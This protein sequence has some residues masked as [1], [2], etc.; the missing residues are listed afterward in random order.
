MR[1]SVCWVAATSLLLAACAAPLDEERQAPNP[2]S[3]VDETGR[4]WATRAP[5]ETIRI[6]GR[7]FVAE[8]VR[9]ALP[10]RLL[11]MPVS[12]NVPFGDATFADLVFV[13]E[14]QGV[15]AAYPWNI[16][17]DL[18]AFMDRPLTF[19]RYQGT[20][21]GL[22]S[23]LRNAMGISA[24]YSDGAVFFSPI[25][26][27]AVSIP[28]IES[29]LDLVASELERMGASDVQPSQVASQILYSASPA[30][31]RDLIDPFLRRSAHNLSE[32]TMQIALVTVSLDDRDERG[33]D[34]DTF[35]ARLE[36]RSPTDAADD[37]DDSGD[38]DDE[39]GG[40]DQGVNLGG[41]GPPIPTFGF[42]NL[43]AGG[44]EGAFFDDD[45]RLFGTD[46]TVTVGAAIDFLSQLGTSRVDQNLEMRTISGSSV[47]LRSG[48][49]L[50]F[51]EQ[52]RTTNNNNNDNNTQTSEVTF[53]EVELGLSVSVTPNF[54]AATNIVTM[55]ISIEQTDL[56]EFLRVEV[57]V[58]ER[59][60]P[61]QRPV[62][63]EQG[64]VDLVRVPA[65]R[66]VII[67]GVSETRSQRDRTA[68]YGLWRIG[69]SVDTSSRSALFIILRPIVTMYELIDNPILTAGV[70]PP[71]SLPLA[72]PD[73]A[74]P[75]GVEGLA[76]PAV[77]PAPSLRPGERPP[78]APPGAVDD[79]VFGTL[80]DSVLGG[81]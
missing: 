34:W 21:A 6:P 16:A 14:D 2:Q 76:P 79:G 27:Y 20:L 46:V 49:V 29:I 71:R 5:I 50:P 72:T 54:E 40:G 65:G 56:I 51:I 12:L 15:T 28:P 57:P 18:E 77:P 32:V 22:I 11:N 25:E 68:P 10:Q 66:T 63:A 36:N 42:G 52:I 9:P 23:K 43:N 1:P 31:Q 7:F 59:T 35:N 69:N 39:D 78:P 74:P 19:R 64:L 58:G 75:A 47:E 62:V 33:F 8:T 61:I 26:Q 44:L 37:D 3:I 80:L 60:E 4:A 81:D 17:E 30:L 45:I 24:W 48:R 70:T 73:G 67:G 55:E 13:L 53:D 38:G 41:F